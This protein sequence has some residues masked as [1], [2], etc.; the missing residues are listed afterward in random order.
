VVGPDWG[1][2]AVKSGGW[3]RRVS[4]LPDSSCNRRRD[5]C[6]MKVGNCAPSEE[7]GPEASVFVDRGLP[8]ASGLD[9]DFLVER[10][11]RFSR[12]VVLSQDEDDRR[13]GNQ[14]S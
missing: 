13:S 6:K 11:C 12:F 10:E 9:K 14:S 3:E 8:Y 2:K 4:I 5:C 7:D 1:W